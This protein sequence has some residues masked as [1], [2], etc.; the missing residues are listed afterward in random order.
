MTTDAPQHDAVPPPIAP[1]AQHRYP[2]FNRLARLHSRIMFSLCVASTVLI[3]AILIAVTGYLI[4][5]GISSLHLSFFTAL[6]IPPGMAGAPGGMKNALIGTAILIL[7]ASA[8]GIPLGMLAGIYLSEY[9][10]NSWLGT[11]TRFLADVLT[12]VPSIV[13][14]I[15]GYELLVAPIAGW[16]G[17]LQL[18]GHDYHLMPNGGFNGYAGAAALAFIMIPIVA[19]TTEEML[20]LVP[21]SYREASIALGATKARTILGVVVPAATGSVVTGI[22]LAIARV[23]G[24]TAPLLFTALGARFMPLAMNAKF[25]WVHAKLDDPFPSLTVQVFNYATG[26]FPA[27]QRLAW[28]GILVLIALI[29]C[30]NLAVRFFTRSARIAQH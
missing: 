20:R 10:S 3:L 23:A 16:S 27:Q 22:M 18:F 13:V 6:P 25:P 21:N 7:L 2:L 19:R 12:G 28:A 14:G 8:A 15:L 4:A 11:P 26:P 17:H 5:I 9:S 30:L 24:E 1:P 29:F